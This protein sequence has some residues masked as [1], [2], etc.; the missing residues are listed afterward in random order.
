M[1]IYNFSIFNL[2]YTSKNV[3]VEEVEAVQ[4]REKGGKRGDEGVKWKYFQKL[5]TKHSQ[6]RC[7]V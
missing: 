6:H 2:Y 4:G 5:L 3:D 7:A 1:R